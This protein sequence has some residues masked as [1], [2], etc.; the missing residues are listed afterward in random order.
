MTVIDRQYVPKSR[1]APNWQA[2]LNDF[3]G[4]ADTS[5]GNESDFRGE[6]QYSRLG[7]VRLVNVL[8]SRELSRR[9]AQHV[10]RDPKDQYIL[11]NVKSGEIELRQHGSRYELNAGS[12][13]L[14]RTDQ[15]FDWIHQNPTSVSNVAIPGHM[16]RARLR[17]VETF[18]LRPQSGQRGVWRVLHDLLES[19]GRHS[20]ALPETVSYTF[21]TQLV[22]LLGAALESHEHDDVPLGVEA[23]RKAM[24]RRCV[25]FMRSNLSDEALNPEK[26][27]QGVGVSVRSLHRLFQESG[28]SVGS[29]LRTIRLEKCCTD[30][31]DPGKA[32]FSIREIAYQAG[33][34]QQA[35]FANIF[36]SRYQMAASEWRRNAQIRA[37]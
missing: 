32:H 19:L 2:Q 34:R 9:T 15:P 11:A 8:S 37:D 1:Q 7:N 33:F 22:E 29:V 28:E 6:V 16:L 26:I 14:F 20:N 18:L 25:A 24:Y 27:A 13:I 35:H 36:K 17:N 12:F 30:L 3:I 21:A 10:R 5:V 4:L 31:A 23:L